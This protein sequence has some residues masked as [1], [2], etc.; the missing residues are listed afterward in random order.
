MKRGTRANGPQFKCIRV[1]IGTEISDFLVT[2][3]SNFP[4]RRIPID[5]AIAL[6]ARA[7]ATLS[8]L[9]RP[10]QFPTLKDIPA[11]SLPNQGFETTNHEAEWFNFM[12]SRSVSQS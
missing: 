9:S 5:R 3:S 12:Q 4:D 7:R 2:L 1:H 8:S 11:D 6:Q 10:P